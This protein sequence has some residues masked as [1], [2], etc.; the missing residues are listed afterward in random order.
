MVG[1]AGLPDFFQAV[2]CGDEVKGEKLDS[3]ADIHRYIDIYID[4]DKRFLI[5][6][7]PIASF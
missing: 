2:V 6:S 5:A 7:E 1:K 4:T 3:Y